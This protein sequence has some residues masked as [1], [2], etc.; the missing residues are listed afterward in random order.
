M[1]VNLAQGSVASAAQDSA[2]L[3]QVFTRITAESCPHFYNFHMHTVFSDGRLK[4]EQVM[5]Q[6]I[7]IGLSGFAITDHHSV[8]GF[9]Q[10]Q[11]WL[12]ERQAPGSEATLPHLWSGVEINADMLADEV[13]LLC[14]AFDPDHEMVQPYLQGKTTTGEHYSAA[15][16]I[17]AVRQAGGLVILAHPSR[18]KRSIAELV[19]EAAR[20]GVDGIETF[21]AY[22]NPSPWKPSP[23]ETQMAY[24]LSQTYGLLNSCGTDTHG[25]NLLQRL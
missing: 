2:A 6:A 13:H 8:N 14:Y 9:R 12:I 21:Y 3:R 25:L 22:N 5:E 11:E 18:Y 23:K 16:V 1:A 4:P 17:A 20:L 19:S 24:E 7:E 15:R 10:A